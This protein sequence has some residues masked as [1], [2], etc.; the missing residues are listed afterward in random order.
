MDGCVEGGVRVSRPD[1]CR[2][3]GRSAADV[4]RWYR[5]AEEMGTLVSMC[6][7]CLGPCTIDAKSCLMCPLS[8]EELDAMRYQL[9]AA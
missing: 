7:C 9:A 4:E 5:R 1:G 3:H 8:S 6:V 2:K